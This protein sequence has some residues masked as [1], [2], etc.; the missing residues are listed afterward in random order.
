MRKGVC[1]KG[2]RNHDRLING[3]QGMIRYF[4]SLPSTNKYCELLDLSTVEEF[5]VFCALEQTSG[6]GQQQ[7]QW[8]SDANQN[9]TFS[10]ILHPTH[11]PIQDQ[12]MLSKVLSLGICHWLDQQIPIPSQIKWPNDI[13]VGDRKIC[14]ILTS[15][16]I[17]GSRLEHAVCGVGL[18]LNQTVFPSWVPNPTSLKQIT[19][20]EY[21][22]QHCLESLISML[23]DSYSLLAAPDWDGLNRQYLQ[24]LYQY[25][26]PSAYRFQGEQIQ[27]TIKGV[28]R[29]GHLQLLT[30]KGTPLSCSMK[31]IQYLINP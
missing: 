13:Y 24:R 18:N 8:V 27:A 26:K 29:Y 28:N 4:D 1:R 20:K 22:I 23:T 12:F 14:G 16:R 11:L 21:D 31:E 30:S 6:I 10:L 2:K 15:T 17:N 5:A 3:F 9:L 25:G 7:S 19:G